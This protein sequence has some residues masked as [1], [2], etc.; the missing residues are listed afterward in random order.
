MSRKVRLTRMIG[1]IDD[2]VYDLNRM[3]FS[4]YRSPEG[5]QPDITAYRYD[6][7]IEIWVDLA[8]VEKSD[9]SVDVLSDRVRV[10]GER[11]PPLPARDMSSRC[12]QV[13][14][15]EIQCGRFAREIVL[16]TEIDR[17]RVSA[18]QENGLLRIVLPLA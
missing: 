9:I 14:T 1:R 2:V 13:L 18:K 12:R 5:W 15:M 11:R 4:A 17:N 7:R 3:H 6:D 10:S 16:P 8:G